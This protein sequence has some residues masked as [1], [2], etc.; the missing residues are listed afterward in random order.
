MYS[1]HVM[2][3]PYMTNKTKRKMKMKRKV[4]QTPFADTG[5]IIGKAAGKIF[6]LPGMQGFGKWLGSG[7]GSIFGSG[8]YTMVGQQPGYN[9][10]TNDRQIP[11]FAG[12]RTNMVCHREFIGDISGTTAFTN[13]AFDINPANTTLFP[14]LSTIAGGYQQY[15]FHGLVFEFRPLITDFVT[16]GAP[17]VVVFATNYNAGEPDFQNKVQMENSEYA[18]S[19]KP[20]INLMHAIECDPQETTLSR[21]YVGVP[22]AGADPRMYNLGKTQFATQGNPNQLLGELWVSY[23]VEFLKPKLSEEVG[24][25]VKSVHI[26]RATYTAASSPLGLVQTSYE[27]DLRVVVSGT[28]ITILNTPPS[29]CYLVLVVWGGSPVTTLMPTFSLTG[30][31]TYPGTF[32]AGG[33]TSLNTPNDGTISDQLQKTLRIRSDDLIGTNAVITLGLSGV[34]PFSGAI[35]VFVTMIDNTT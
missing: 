6:G 8:D 32:A 28:S 2:G 31:T 24:G 29:Q 34:V 17:G 23:A 12:E 20:T 7:I 25:D 18:V 4:K 16:S 15:R 14:W 13:N 27:G 19:V 10:L 5:A 22:P 21:L 30:C 33:G 11:K 3:I 35:D 26:E 1:P 9:I